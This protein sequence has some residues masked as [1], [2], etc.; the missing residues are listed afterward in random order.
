ARRAVGAASP[1]SAGG[2]RVN[3][4]L[5][6]LWNVVSSDSLY[7]STVRFSALLAFAAIGEWV[8]ERTGKLNISVEAMLLCGA[9][10]SALGSYLSHNVWIAVLC[11]VIGGLVI[12]LVQANMSHRLAANKVNVGRPL[13]VPALR[14]PPTLP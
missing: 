10:G 2:G 3:D 6:A 5:H 13:N 11:G 8:A 1:S 9:F 14:P 12:A 7:E 4:F